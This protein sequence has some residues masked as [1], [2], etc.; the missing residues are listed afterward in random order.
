MIPLLLLLTVSPAC[1]EPAARAFDFWVGEWDVL[2]RW[3]AESGE[4]IEAGRA[5]NQVFHVLDGCAVV[6][7]WDGHLGDSHIRGFSVRAWDPA[8]AEWVLVL[9]WP[10]PGRPTFDTL[11]GGF[12]HG[13]GDFHRQ[14]VNAEGDMVLT[15]Y[16]FSDITPAALRWN[17][18]TSLDGGRTWATQWIME[19]TRRDPVTDPPLRNV[20]LA[21]PGRT[22]LCPG[23]TAR[24]FDPYL[25]EWTSA[26]PVARLESMAIVGECAILDQLAWQDSDGLRHEALFVRA[27][28]PDG[29]EWVQYAL[30]TIDRRFVRYAGPGPGRLASE[31]AQTLRWSIT[32][33]GSAMTL[34][35]DGA[36]RG[37][38][39][40]ALERVR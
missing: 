37:G 16:T 25:G 39:T 11:R 35:W 28:A 14:S 38:R 10:R 8:T 22:R 2:N 17:D 9:N 30:D 18:G 29:G 31:G 19:F 40:F 20:P 3:R 12:R 27:L 13:R 4:W 5:T 6:E 21:D 33:D 36:P 32:A 1:D 26:E 24:A 34:M 15:R 7:L 23:D